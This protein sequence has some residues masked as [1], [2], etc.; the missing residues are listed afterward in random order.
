MT[1]IKLLDQPAT[2]SHKPLHT[3]T[4]HAYLP[5][6]ILASQRVRGRVPP[7]F[8]TVLKREILQYLKETYCST[9]RERD[10]LQWGER[11]TIEERETCVLA[12]REKITVG[13]LN[14]D[15]TYIYDKREMTVGRGNS[16]AHVYERELQEPAWSLACD[17]I[18][19]GTEREL[20][21]EVCRSRPD[22]RTFMT[23]MT[24]QDHYMGKTHSIC[25]GKRQ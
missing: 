1:L 9:E 22:S 7:R 2:I 14:W 3:K 20:G 17:I 18:T 15:N 6:G 23:K 16:L 24:Y 13:Y 5:V 19:S 4:T 25:G 12:L 10:V 11:R 8:N 21:T